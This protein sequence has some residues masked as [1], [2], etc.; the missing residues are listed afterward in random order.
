MCAVF[1]HSC[2]CVRSKF[3]WQSKRAAHASAGDEQHMGSMTTLQ[4]ESSHR[5][6]VGSHAC[7]ALQ[8]V[9]TSYPINQLSRA[10]SYA[11]KAMTQFLLDSRCQHMPHHQCDHSKQQVNW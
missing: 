3:S 6:R 2:Q 10:V 8:P 4:Y 5:W 1:V 7:T 11:G 9:L